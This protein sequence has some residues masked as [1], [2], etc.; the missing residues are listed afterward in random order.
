MLAPVLVMVALVIHS[1]KQNMEERWTQCPCVLVARPGAAQK[2]IGWCCS[3]AA[4]SLD[5]KSASRNMREGV[6]TGQKR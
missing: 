2:G 3:A 6:S 1:S 5:A 4:G